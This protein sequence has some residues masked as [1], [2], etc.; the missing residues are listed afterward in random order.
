MS[1]TQTQTRWPGRRL[2]ASFLKHIFFKTKYFSLL[3]S[4]IELMTNDFKDVYLPADA[5][6]SVSIL[7]GLGK[8]LY[9]VVYQ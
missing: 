2:S 8:V 3:N 1:L 6:F 9:T 4:S 5:L 7:L